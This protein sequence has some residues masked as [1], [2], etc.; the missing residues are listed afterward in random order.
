MSRFLDPGLEASRWEAVPRDNGGRDWPTTRGVI[1]CGSRL[2]SRRIFGP[3][4]SGEKEFSM[5]PS[6]D[7]PR[8]L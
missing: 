3:K 8:D 7:S 6:P 4:Q 1:N 5:G 2:R